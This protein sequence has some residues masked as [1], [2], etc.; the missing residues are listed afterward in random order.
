MD[1]ATE[2][3]AQIFSIPNLMSMF[4]I[5]LIPFFAAAVLQGRTIAAIALIA[6][7]ALMDV[8]DGYVARRFHMVTQLGKVLDPVAD[9]L[10]LLVLALCL[11]RQ[12]PRVWLLA[13]VMALKEG[14]MLVL[15]A[16]FLR[17]G[18]RPE[19]SCWYGKA[20]TAA[21]YAVM[22]LMLLFPAW[23]DGVCTGL[24]LLCAGWLLVCGALYIRKYWPEWKRLKES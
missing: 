1:Q 20:G 10:T 21:L 23:P 5:V 22:T 2:Q 17:R 14:A 11:A 19:S 15:C 8:A 13:G 12:N 3:R 7:S 9:K 18:G 4:R 24:I 6:V 16:L